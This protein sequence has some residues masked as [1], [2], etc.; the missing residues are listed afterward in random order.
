[1]SS[2]GTRARPNRRHAAAR[3]SN[4]NM[5][6]T[7]VKNVPPR[8]F[9]AIGLVRDVREIY[10]SYAPAFCYRQ[11]I[12]HDNGPTAARRNKTNS[13][14]HD[15]FNTILRRRFGFRFHYGPRIITATTRAPD[16]FDALTTA[17]L[18][19]ANGAFALYAHELIARCWSPRFPK[20]SP[21]RPVGGPI[22]SFRYLSGP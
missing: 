16:A 5:P 21:A 15:R 7:S 19:R 20:K 14:Y 8:R 18:C 22:F 3:L 13:T 12:N 17:T 11:P 1:M 2:P 6:A 10:G 4:V 9:A